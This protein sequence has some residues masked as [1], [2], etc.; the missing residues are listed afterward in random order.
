MI[1]LG[2]SNAPCVN[3]GGDV[4]VSNYIINADTFTMELQEILDQFGCTTG[5]P[6]QDYKGTYYAEFEISST[7]IKSD[8]TPDS[9]RQDYYKFFPLTFSF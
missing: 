1:L 5:Q 4:D 2:N 9:T 3:T 8:G 6:S 7:P